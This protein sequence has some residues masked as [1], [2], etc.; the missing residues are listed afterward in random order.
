MA[1]LQDLE[2]SSSPS[3]KHRQENEGQEPAT[4]DSPLN[5]AN[6][7]E[8]IL[9]SLY[10]DVF[11]QI[12][13]LSWWQ[14]TFQLDDIY[15]ELELETKKG[16]LLFDRD[17]LFNSNHDCSNPRRILLEG[18][19]G[20]GKSTFCYKFAKDWATGGI[21]TLKDSKLLFL[22]NLQ[23]CQG[24]LIDS[25]FETLLP[26]NCQ[27]DRDS[28]LEYIRRNQE[29]I[30]LL[31]DGW[32]EMANTTNDE[33]TKLLEGRMLRH[34]KVLLTSRKI[35][36]DHSESDNKRR[37]HFDRFVTIRG[38]SH[39]SL[40]S[41]IR[42]HF[43]ATEN[44]LKTADKIIE[45]IDKSKDQ[46]TIMSLMVCPMNALLMCDV[47]KEFGGTLTTKITPLY[48]RILQLIVKRYLEKHDAKN[49]ITHEDINRQFI[50]LGKLAA[51]AL[52]GERVRYDKSELRLEENKDILRMGFLTRYSDRRLLSS[53][54]LGLFVIHHKTF[55]EFF[56]AKYLASIIEEHSDE[57]L[58]SPL[59][60]S[61]TKPLFRFLAGLLNR[62]ADLMFS[63]TILDDLS[64]LIEC[65]LETDTPEK[66]VHSVVSSLR[67]KMTIK[68]YLDA[69]KERMNDL[70]VKVIQLLSFKYMFF[71]VQLSVNQRKGLVNFKPLLEALSS[72]GK[73][74]WLS[75]VFGQQIYVDIAQKGSP[76]VR[77]KLMPSSNE[78]VCSS[79]CKQT[80][81]EIDDNATK[82]PFAITSDDIDDI[83]LLLDE[84]NI[85]SFVRDLNVV[86]TT[87]EMTAIRNLIQW[88]KS[89]NSCGQISISTAEK[90]DHGN[91]S[92]D[93]MEAILNFRLQRELTRGVRFDLTT[94]QDGNVTL[95]VDSD[96]ETQSEGHYSFKFNECE[97]KTT[98]DTLIKFIKEVNTSTD[99]FMNRCDLTQCE[100]IDMCKDIR[101]SKVKQLQISYP[102]GDQD[103]INL[104]QFEEL[105]D[106]VSGMTELFSLSI[107]GWRFPREFSDRSAW[108]TNWKKLFANLQNVRVSECLPPDRSTLDSEAH[109]MITGLCLAWS[110]VNRLTLISLLGNVLNEGEVVELQ[111]AGILYKREIILDLCKCKVSERSGQ[112]LQAHKDFIDIKIE[113]DDTKYFFYP[114]N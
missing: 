110:G 111:H 23:Q 11:S 28:L 85:R 32:D 30:V 53:D 98:K 15:I 75:I 24:S 26:S 2:S 48:D 50:F 104:Q 107:S 37:A 87:F 41:F 69:D 12:R 78:L 6:K 17:E 96:L 35:H 73:Q 105:V 36:S 8:N 16:I 7:C 103:H 88:W 106:V 40:R 18:D 29:K 38:F 82:H 57:I 3:A 55:Q 51:S 34:C 66:L 60:S 52:R 76:G 46:Q 65:L 44:T 25:I 113:N 83:F 114:D 109:P 93:I 33:I 90:F 101:D 100:F 43:L 64:F 62:K 67:S 95:I 91:P 86:A 59:I 9:R 1:S 47:W 63:K 89:Q 13:P 84:S 74:V 56:A 80:L 21:E 14:K 45:Q 19:P 31:L 58:V 70:C 27:I 79:D 92:R 49:Q 61:Q 72:K 108:E 94:H 22:L 99:L 39:D 71:S 102:A 5:A 4:S 42:K 97:V 10:K 54:P 20:Y 112:I 77:G 68:V 81:S